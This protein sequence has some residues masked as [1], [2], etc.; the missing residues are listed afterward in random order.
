M[1]RLNYH[2]LLYFW[3]VARKGTIAEACK[4]LHLAQPTVSGQI[5]A[6]ERSLGAKLFDRIG[7]NLV[8]TDQG[9]VVYR[10]ADEI[11]SLGRELQDTMA[12]RPTGHGLRL[13]VG[14]AD[15]LPRLIVYR[16]LEPALHLNEP[17]QLVCHDDK[18]E[19]L[20][21]RL[22]MNQLDVVLSDVSVSPTVKVR[23][24][25]HLLGECGV[26][27]LGSAELVAKYRR[28]FPQSLEG[29]PFLLP[30]DGTALRRLLDQ[31]FNTEDI[32][33]M[34]VGEFGDYDLFEVFGQVGAGII[35]IPTVV[36][37]ETLRQNRLRL[38]G[39]V[40]S[41]REQ[42]FAI[43]IERKLKHPA[44]VAISEVARQKLFG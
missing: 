18:T 20:L 3:T 34:I 31:W 9:R 24:F 13:D 1:N 23:A 28:G 40:D 14:V 32:R 38:L 6:L 41:I 5:R 4:E 43:S 16:L 19:L 22:A 26:S 30:A 29:A 37:V 15:V 44:V 33:P 39:R 42:F 12:G 11:F 25:N 8:L 17:V 21:A 2:H 27:F 35:A 7:R 36:E 10:Y